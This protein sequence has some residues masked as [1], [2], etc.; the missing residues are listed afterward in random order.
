[1]ARNWLGSTFRH[2]HNPCRFEGGGAHSHWWSYIAPYFTRDFRVAAIDLSGMGGWRAHYNSELRA[3]EI[4]AVMLTRRPA[5]WRRRRGI[6]LSGR[7]W[8][9]SVSMSPSTLPWRASV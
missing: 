6:R 3:E 5:R 2:P 9:T 1:M 8:V 7:P 4:R